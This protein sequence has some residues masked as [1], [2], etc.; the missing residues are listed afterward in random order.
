MENDQPLHFTSYHTL[1]TEYMTEG[2]GFSKMDMM[3]VTDDKV[4]DT[5]EMHINLERGVCQVASIHW[6]AG[7]CRCAGMNVQKIID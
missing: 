2:T 4:R 6:R 3:Y 1:Q 5:Q 7:H